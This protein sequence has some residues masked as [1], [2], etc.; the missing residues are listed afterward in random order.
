MIVVRGVRTRRRYLRAAGI[1]VSPVGGGAF[2]AVTARVFVWPDL[3]PLP[4]HADAI[5]ELGGPRIS[6]GTG[7]LSNWPAST[8]RRCSSSRRCPVTPRACR[9]SP[10]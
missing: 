8:R 5:I 1:G 9:R 6:T 7:W 10:A 3:Q 4:E 2:V